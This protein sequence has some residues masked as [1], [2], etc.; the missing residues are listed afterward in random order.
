[1]NIIEVFLASAE[2]Y[3][4]KIAIVDPKCTIT[5]SELRNEL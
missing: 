4:D 2:K 1:M 5:F 3:P